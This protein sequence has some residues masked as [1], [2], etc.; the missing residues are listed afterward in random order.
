[1]PRVANNSYKVN[2]VLEQ[3]IELGTIAD[4][5]VVPISTSNALNVD[6]DSVN[7]VTLNLGNTTQSNSLPVTIAADDILS[8]SSNISAVSDTAKTADATT[9]TAFQVGMY[10]WDGSNWHRVVTTGSGNLKAETF[11]EQHK[12]SQGNISNNVTHAAGDVSSPVTTNCSTIVTLLGNTTDTS[13]SIIP[14][15]SADNSNWYSLDFEIFPQENGDIFG[16]IESVALNYFRVQ[17]PGA[18]TTT[19]TALHNAH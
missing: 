2:D 4:G 10:G 6:L 3:V 16:N 19:L 11:L 17:Y 15:A 7:G 12:G 14:Q 1:M 8:V 9:A 13:N 5:V 18:G